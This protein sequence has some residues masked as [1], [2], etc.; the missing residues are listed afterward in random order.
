MLGSFLSVKS[1]ISCVKIVCAI[2]EQAARDDILAIGVRH[3]FW[4]QNYSCTS[5]QLFKFCGWLRT[6]EGAEQL[7]IIQKQA[8]LRKRARPGQEVGTVALV[9]ILS[10][11]L[12]D[13]LEEKKGRR[14]ELEDEITELRLRIA[15]KQAELARDITRLDTEFRPASEYKQMDEQDLTRLCFEKYEEECRRDEKEAALLSESLLEMVRTRYANEVRE[16]HMYEFCRVDGRKQ[17][18]LDY[19][20]QKIAFAVQVGE[21]RVANSFRRY[22]AAA[23]GEMFDEVERRLRS[24]LLSLVPV[25]V[26][27]EQVGGPA[28]APL[29]SLL[30]TERVLVKQVVGRKPPQLFFF[31]RLRQKVE[32][33]A[34]NVGLLFG[35]L[36]LEF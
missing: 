27:A 31:P 16:S 2:T 15:M 6:L 23:G 28:N 32:M 18:L 20:H 10:Q 30:E 34:R 21:P 11:Q 22:L 19:A 7:G 1:F 36:R 33:M 24:D 13:F 5:V 3:F 35:N 25:G 17:L 26:E 4:N 12:S 8:T 29:A 9:H 14:F